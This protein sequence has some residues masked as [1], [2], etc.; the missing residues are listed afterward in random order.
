MFTYE[1]GRPL[2]PAYASRLFETLRDQ[3]GPVNASI[4]SLR[5]MHASLLLASGADIAIVS[6]RI[7]HSTI[8]LT[9]DVYSHLIASASRRAAEGASALVPRLNEHT[10]RLGAGRA[11]KCREARTRYFRVIPGLSAVVASEVPGVA[12]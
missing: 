6:K 7:G 2:R 3:A 1:D 5:H 9:S 8:A 12:T 11:L 10:G 4:H